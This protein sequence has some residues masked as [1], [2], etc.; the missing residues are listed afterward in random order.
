MPPFGFN[1]EE[2]G[3]GMTISPM[4]QQYFDV[5]A[6]YDKYILFYRIGDFY[7]MFY[8]DAKTA[9]KELDL[10]LTGRDCGQDDRAPMCGVPFHSCDGYIS[11]LISRGYK[12]AICEQTEDPAKAKGLVKRDVIRLIT[13]GTVTETGMLEE[14]KNN[15]LCSVFDR[16]GHT[17]LAFADV[18]TGAVCATATDGGVNAVSCELTRFSPRE[19]IFNPDIPEKRKAA[20][21][22][23]C[24]LPGE[25]GF[26]DDYKP[27][28]TARNLKEN[29]GYTA[30]GG[31]FAEA[32]AALSAAVGYI[33]DVYKNS[34]KFAGKIEWY[35][36]DRYMALDA[37]ARRNLELDRNM[38]TGDKKGS[39]LS[40]IDGTKTAM[41]RRLLADWLQKP[42]VDCVMIQKRQNAV[43]QLLDDDIGEAKLGDLLSGIYDID[44]IATRVVYGTANARELKALSDAMT[45]LPALKNAC[46]GYSAALLREIFD[47]TDPLEDVCG[48]ISDAL[49]DDLPLAVT[50]GGLI[51]EGYDAEVDRLRALLGD[52]H[53]ALAKI[54]SD[55]REKSGI[56]KLKIGYNRVFGYYLEITRGNTLPVP[57][58]F[59]RKQTL[60]TGERYITPELKELEND[61]L[62]G[63]EKLTGLEYEL[64]CAL[65]GQVGAAGPRIKQTARS[66]AMLDVFLSFAGTARKND[67]CRPE[68][69][70]G[71][72]I[73]IKDGRHPVVERLA[74]GSGFV[75]NDTLADCGENKILVITGPNMAGKSTYMRQN[76]LIVILAQIG[77]FVPAKSA[78]IGV[79]DAIFTRVG[80]SDDLSSGQSTFM[81]EMSE[82]AYILKNATA[83]SLIILDEIGRGTSTFDGMSIA[84]AV[85]EYIADAKKIGAKTMFATHYHE[86]CEMEARLD[87]VKNYNILVK[88]RGDEI[89][90]LRKIA[91]GGAD[92]SYG[93]EVSKLAGVP[94]AVVKRAK[95]ILAELEKDR[96]ERVWADKKQH[97]GISDGEQ[98]A[99]ADMQT[100]KLLQDLRNLDVNTVSPLEALTLLDEFSKKAKTI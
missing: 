88:K 39:L 37:T 84:R 71:D 89:T 29:F 25:S 79:V 35:T 45:R 91:R 43:A 81:V 96:D 58:Y 98:G 82:L 55:E 31:D 41:G 59:I 12:V 1:A 50:E 76:A 67:F 65:R 22:N 97:G 4:M 70:N 30:L 53:A 73:I 34:I 72:A 100:Q 15:Y 13:P 3:Y 48:L 21:L 94:E 66:V 8:D 87:C 28:N 54:E 78:K 99:F 57:D 61:I 64:F 11:R 62:Q 63:R 60:T 9:S 68:V 23:D 38:R 51:R 2:R 93:I 18:S 42:L 86:L 5:K 47:G 92:D 69:D 80:A 95:V 83:K 56:S 85:V 52:S 7:E 6:K 17:G 19:I 32:E 46:A 40:V 33:Q 26:D 20:I 14:G 10:V 27:D 75:P 90:F 49:K 77:S 36:A 16:G 44:R 24:G 74:A